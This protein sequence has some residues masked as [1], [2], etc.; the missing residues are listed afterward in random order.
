MF[1]NSAR[2][3]K[4]TFAI[5]NIYVARIRQK[6]DQKITKSTRAKQFEE[7]L[8]DRIRFNQEISPIWN[9]YRFDI[10]LPV[11]DIGKVEFKGSD[12]NADFKQ[13]KDFILQYEENWIT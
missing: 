4:N 9:K 13:L 5:K 6:K 7:E 10:L 3:V 12:N 11:T 1:S 8:L 2:G